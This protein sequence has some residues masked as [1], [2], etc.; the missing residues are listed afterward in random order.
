MEN[1]TFVTAS[2]L[3]EKDIA[4]LHGREHELRLAEEVAVRAVHQCA[5]EVAAALKDLDE[6][7]KDVEKAMSESQFVKFKDDVVQ[8][9]ASALVEDTLSSDYYDALSQKIAKTVLDLN[10]RGACGNKNVFSQKLRAE[11]SP[12]IAEYFAD[13]AIETLK[14]WENHP[15]GRWKVFVNDIVGLSEK[16]QELGARRFKGKQ[17]LDYV[18]I[19]VESLLDVSV[20]QEQ[21]QG[22]L[23]WLET[24]AGELCEGFFSKLLNVITCGFFKILGLELG[25]SEEQIL[26]DYAGSIC[27]RLKEFFCS[28]PVRSV[29][30]VGLLPVFLETHRRVINALEYTR[31]AYRVKIK[32]RCDELIR[33]HHASDEALRRI[34]EENRKLREGGFVPLCAC[35]ERK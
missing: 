28:A 24:V 16:I 1:H 4:T 35:I 32:A 20:I 33:L 23:G 19:P 11:V 29:L 26:A 2:H 21:I 27:P 31:T 25:R 18:P 9:L 8:L 17:L 6:Y 15:S 7:D 10:K 13:H 14:A 5:D 3:T 12:M 22:S 34:V 30:V